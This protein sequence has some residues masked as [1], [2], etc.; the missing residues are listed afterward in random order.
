MEYLLAI[1][2]LINFYLT[3]VINA[4]EEYSVWWRTILLLCTAS[5]CL[6]V[7]VFEWVNDKL[8][9]YDWYQSIK[10]WVE[11]NVLGSFSGYNKEHVS[12][13][14]GFVNKSE[15][16]YSERLKSNGNALN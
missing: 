13:M 10:F 1:Y 11:L 12:A 2:F 14:D 3:G 16:K 7:P 15:G 5:F 6:L 8:L 9:Q 4:K